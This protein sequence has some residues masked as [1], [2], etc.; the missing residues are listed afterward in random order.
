MG[1]YPLT[2]L[3]F[4]SIIVPDPRR[5]TDNSALVLPARERLLVAPSPLY[6]LQA[7]STP[8]E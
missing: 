3:V 4:L 8:R 7:M 6:E 5:V 2:Q 1:S